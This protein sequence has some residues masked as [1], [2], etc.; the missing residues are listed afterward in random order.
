MK[1]QPRDT[2]N[3]GYKTPNDDNQNKKHK[4]GKM[5]KTSKTNKGQIK[6]LSMDKQLFSFL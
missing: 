4:T 1:G 3:I 2:G 6:L 5:S